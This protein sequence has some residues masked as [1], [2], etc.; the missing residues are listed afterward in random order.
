[1]AAEI[2]GTATEAPRGAQKAQIGTV[3]SNK[4][5]KTVVVQVMRLVKHAKYKKYV[6][7][8]RK[9][10]AHDERQECQVGDKVL[11]VETRPLSREKRWKVQQ[12]LERAA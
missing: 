6:K 7:R 10:K 12:I 2:Q 11:I 5:T 8:W 4:M 3:V 9:F 1:M